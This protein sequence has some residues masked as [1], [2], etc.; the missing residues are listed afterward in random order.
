M[1]AVQLRVLCLASTMRTYKT[2]K[3]G[4]GDFGHHEMTISIRIEWEGGG[5]GRSP[6]RYTQLNVCRRKAIRFPTQYVRQLF[7]WLGGKRATFDSGR[8]RGVAAIPYRV[9]IV[10]HSNFGTHPDALRQLRQ[11]DTHTRTRPAYVITTLQHPRHARAHPDKHIYMWHSTTDTSW[12]CRRVAGRNVQ[13]FTICH[14]CAWRAHPIYILHIVKQT[15]RG[16][17]TVQIG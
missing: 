9:P 3:G 13:I 4:Y 16:V 1:C 10:W 6:L 12:R 11:T 15:F 7:R 5:W 2:P 14:E 8:I 17:G